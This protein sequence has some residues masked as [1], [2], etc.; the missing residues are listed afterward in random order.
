MRFDD[1]DGHAIDVSVARSLNALRHPVS[2]RPARSSWNAVGVGTY[3]YFALNS[4]TGQFGAD[5]ATESD[6]YNGV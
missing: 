3:W 1:D 5:L 2:Y 4:V 6:G